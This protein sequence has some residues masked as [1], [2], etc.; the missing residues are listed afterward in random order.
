[1]AKY[2]LIGRTMV[3]AADRDDHAERGT[4]LLGKRLD[5]KLGER[6]TVRGTLRVIQHKADVVN[7]VIVSA[8]FRTPVDATC[9]A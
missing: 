4:L 2:T 7:G 5:V 9:C 8:W 3:G 1:V 6:L